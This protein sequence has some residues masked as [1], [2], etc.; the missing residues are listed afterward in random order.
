MIRDYFAD[1]ELTR[2]ASLEE[3]KS[4]YRLLAR[5]FHPDLNPRDIY[6]AESF[7][8][9][10]E[11]YEALQTEE[12]L[13]LQRARLDFSPDM[14]EVSHWRRGPHLVSNEEKTWPGDPKPE[15]RKE[16]LDLHLLVRV[17]KDSMKRGSKRVKFLLESLCSVCEGAGGDNSAVKR[18][19]K[20]CA[21]LAY[22]MI[23]RGAFRWKKTCE[24]CMGKGYEILRACPSCQGYGKIREEV[25]LDLA[26]P[27]Q[28]DEA[29]AS[30]YKEK[31]HYSIDGKTRGDLWVN[32]RT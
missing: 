4:S 11:A 17:D 16:S 5:R 13:A 14:D 29:R 2:E 26:I 10:R 1:L 30:I 20:S 9:I 6:A 22:Q 31:G 19:C 18:T 12:S 7:R 21:G 3:V 25:T 8:R 23:R 32:W 28:I 24:S 27:R 15:R